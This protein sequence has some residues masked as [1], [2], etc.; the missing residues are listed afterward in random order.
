VCGGVVNWRYYSNL[1][2]AD[3]LQVTGGGNLST[4]A[5]SIYAGSGAPQGYPVS[6]PWTLDLEP[7][8]SNFELVSVVSGAGTVASPWIVQ[9]AY[10]G[11][12][13][14]T[15]AAGVAIAHTWSAGDLTAAASHYQ[16]GSGTGVH[17]LPATAWLGNA[18]V[19]FNETTLLNST[20]SVI[21][22]SGIPQT[23]AHLLVSV[24]A[25]LTETTALT[26]DITLN[27]N[28]DTGADYS[29]V[30]VDATNIT[31]SFVGPVATTAYAVGGIPAFRVTASQGGA[32]DNAGGGFAWIPNYTSAV[33]N[34]MVFAMS[35]GGNGT[36]SMVDARLRW[37]WWNPS[38]SPSLTS[39]SLTAPAGSYFLTGSQFSL[40]GVG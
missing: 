35:G 12:T 21:T 4:S 24:E 34:T 20:T 3:T 2:V 17:G 33:F 22:W 36:S 14:K 39:L 23:S 9:R 13:A 10:D 5:T 28:G 31:G 26:D 8:T 25:R 29:Y 27:F 7:G 15:H 18:A 40:Y 37:G 16:L 30:N 6:F 1:A 19:T 11:T 32:P 38:S